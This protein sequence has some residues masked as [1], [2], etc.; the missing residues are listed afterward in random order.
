MSFWCERKHFKHFIVFTPLHS[1]YFY[2]FSKHAAFI[3]AVN[4]DK[5]NGIRTQKWVETCVEC[6]I[7]IIN[8]YQP[9]LGQIYP[10]SLPT[11]LV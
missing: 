11:P 6:A 1:D 9:K 5:G 10:A 7:Q 2:L 3:S 8:D 4:I